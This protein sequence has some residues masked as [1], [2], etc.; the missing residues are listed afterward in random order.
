MTDIAEASSTDPTPSSPQLASSE[1]GPLPTKHGEIG[2]DEHVTAE[3]ARA[4]SSSPMNLPARHPEDRGDAT[5]PTATPAPTSDNST[6]S[7]NSTPPTTD[8]SSTTPSMHQRRFL[9]FLDKKKIPTYWG[10]RITTVL[11]LML[12]LS[13]LGGTI[14]GWVLTLKKVAAGEA[15]EQSQLMGSSSAIFIH[16]V[17]GIAVLAQ[18]IF[19]ER[20]LFML[21]A[22]RYTFKHPGQIIPSS[23]F[24]GSGQD[25][26]FAWGPWNRPPLPTYAAALAESG[27]GTGDVEDHLI[28]QPPPPAYGTT[29]GSTLI[30]QGFLRNSL[31]AQRP[32]SVHTQASRRNSGNSLHSAPG[33]RPLSYRSTDSG[34]EVIQDAER[35]R[36]LE[37]T[38]SSLERPRPA[39]P[40]I[41]SSRHSAEQR[42]GV[43]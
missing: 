14:A 33:D 32:P 18:L 43:E 39:A 37:Q 31:L 29:R 2:F 25:P 5:E 9:K 24:Q 3:A 4:S 15:D 21:R 34:W 36:M 6:P 23:R 27:V 8:A 22:Q 10:L 28:A 12:Q 11:I 30:L 7:N 20:R 17:F 41:R 35:A 40:S 1:A 42:P 16:A 38:L 13:I 19:L 26:G